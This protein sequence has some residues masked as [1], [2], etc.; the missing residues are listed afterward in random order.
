MEKA[1]RPADGKVRVTANPTTG[2]IFTLQRDE[3]GAPKLDK[4]KEEYGFI[5][6]EQRSL[7]ENEEAAYFNG[8][9]E[10]RSALRAFSRSAWEKVK[11]SFFDGME[12]K[13]KIV[14]EDSLEQK[15]NG[16][17]PRQAGQ[18]GPML[19]ANKGKQIFRNTFFTTNEAAQDSIIKHENDLRRNKTELTPADK[20]AN[21]LN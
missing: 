16:F 19:T 3:N 11:D 5:R 1:K 17:K 4:N 6:L 9:I 14:H 7:S 13:G 12:M 18:D 10:V 21:A 8:G 2:E 20:N 15:H